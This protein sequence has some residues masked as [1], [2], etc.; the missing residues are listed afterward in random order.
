MSGGS[1]SGQEQ[2]NKTKNLSTCRRISKNTNRC[3]LFLL[4]SAEKRRRGKERLVSFAAGRSGEGDEKMQRQ[5]RG[6]ADDE[7]C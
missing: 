7:G 1:G 5:V 4:L 3:L 2:A 6:L